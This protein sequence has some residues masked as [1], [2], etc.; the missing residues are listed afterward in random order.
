VAALTAE[1]KMLRANE[2]LLKEEVAKQAET[3]SEMQSQL[4]LKSYVHESISCFECMMEPI[5]TDRFKC[6]TCDADYDLCLYCY[7]RNGGG[8]AHP[9]S[10]KFAILGPLG[11]RIVRESE[12]PYF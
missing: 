10:H 9:K 3:L 8:S 5:R 2:E 6:L 4:A 12:V 1:V 7:C 11:V